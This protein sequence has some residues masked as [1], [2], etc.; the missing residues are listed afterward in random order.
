M[1]LLNQYSASV[2]GIGTGGMF[3]VLVVSTFVF[4]CFYEATYVSHLLPRANYKWPFLNRLMIIYYII[5]SV[6]AGYC[7]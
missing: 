6:Y 2:N 7:Y 1:H 5:T 3:R 4:L